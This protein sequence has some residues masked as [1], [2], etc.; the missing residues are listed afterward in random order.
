MKVENY[1][2]E[3]STLMIDIS[4]ED[5]AEAAL[6]SRFHENQNAGVV[7][8]VVPG[9]FARNASEWSQAS[10]FESDEFGAR[11]FIRDKC[12]FELRDEIE[13]ELGRKHRLER[14]RPRERNR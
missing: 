9:P 12:K 14:R 10:E 6:L 4:A 7:A 1:H 5:K 2:F 13:N 11:I 3:K 8:L